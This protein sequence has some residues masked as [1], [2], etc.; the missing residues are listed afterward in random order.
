MAIGVEAG[1]ATKPARWTAEWHDL[2]DEVVQ[3][4]LCTGCAGCVI[5]CPHDVLDLSTGTWQ[6]ELRPEA[7]VDGDA[8][9][10]ERGEKGCTLCTR[11][12]PRFRFWEVDADREMFGRVRT[13]DEAV[14]IEQGL[15]LVEATDRRIAEAGQDGGFATALL[16]YA[17]ANDY[18]DGALVSYY[19]ENWQTTPGVATTPDELLAAAGSRYTYSANTL[20]YDEAVERGLSRLG[21]I[22]VG[23]QTSVAAVAAARGARSTSRRIALTVGLLCSKTFDEEI[24][25]ELFEARYGVTRREITKINIKG[26][27]QLWLDRDQGAD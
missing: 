19:D 16:A 3:P 15:Y 11:A 25:E 23:C 2:V 18:I 26:K 5:A 27:L 8:S 22:S 12:C 1:K 7:R 17:L 4:G 9:R 6:P 20:A 24:F 14:G 21:L 10:C 13:P